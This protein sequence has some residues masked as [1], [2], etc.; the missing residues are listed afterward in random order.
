MSRL[1]LGLR[2]QSLA[3]LISSLLA[4]NQPACQWVDR[5]WSLSY[6]H[7]RHIKLTQLHVAARRAG[8]DDVMPLPPE[9]DEL[10]TGCCDV[11]SLSRH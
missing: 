8:S 10:F 6:C 5:L 9:C 7:C 2:L 4:A 3:W 11:M 1:A